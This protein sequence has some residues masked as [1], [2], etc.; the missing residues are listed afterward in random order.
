MHELFL[1]EDDMQ[2]LS[3]KAVTE[4]VRVGHERGLHHL[5]FAL[6]GPMNERR[7]QSR[8]TVTSPIGQRAWVPGPT[9][10]GRAWRRSAFTTWLL[11]RL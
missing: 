4:Y 3:P 5:S 7:D 2:I 11:Q 10:P 6:H 8:S 9:T 1:C